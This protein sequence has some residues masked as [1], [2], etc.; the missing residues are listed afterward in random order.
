MTNLDAATLS[1]LLG[2]AGLVSIIFT[3]YN[4]FRNP[5]I[6][7]DKESIKLREDIDSLQEQVHEIKTKHLTSVEE[8]IK[9]LSK[10]IHDLAINVTR[11]S[12]IID[13]RIPKTNK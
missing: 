2:F 4:S 7:T 9:D 1:Y 12:T 8:N 11:L 5:Q 6:K 13:E 3:V 10:T